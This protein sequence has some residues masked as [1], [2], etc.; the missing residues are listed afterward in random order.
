MVLDHLTGAPEPATLAPLSGGL[1]WDSQS[2]A[3]AL[4]A[5]TTPKLSPGQGIHPVNSRTV[6]AHMFARYSRRLIM[7]TPLYSPRVSNAWSPVTI[8]SARAVRAVLR[9]NSIAG[10][11]MSM[12]MKA[13]A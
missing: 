7:R 11:R 2:L 6:S 13:M 1:A 3:D 10:L 4:C 12:R 9:K 8:A 5:G